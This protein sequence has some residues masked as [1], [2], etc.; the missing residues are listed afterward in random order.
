MGSCVEDLRMNEERF[1]LV[2]DS[3]ENESTYECVCGNGAMS[4][5]VESE[6]VCLSCCWYF[7]Q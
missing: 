3:H 2:R 4:E 1:T 6:K 5:R 7:L